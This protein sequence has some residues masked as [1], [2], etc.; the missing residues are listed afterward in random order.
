M[1]VRFN[2][3]YIVISTF[4]YWK[5]WQLASKIVA[6]SFEQNISQASYFENSL[7]RI[8]QLTVL[9]AVQEVLYWF[10]V[11]HF[12]ITMQSSQSNCN[13][14]V[15][16]RSDIASTSSSSSSSIYNN[17][18]LIDSALHRRSC[19]AGRQHRFYKTLTTLKVCVHLTKQ[20]SLLFVL[21]IIKQLSLTDICWIFD[22]L[23]IFSAPCS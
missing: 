4:S 19:A 12:Y 2:W 9:F 1:R 6:I 11:F 8:K 16:L 15:L 20:L 18:I 10:W 14:I 7:L 22:K 5:A 23:S 21:F 13:S 3:S 17:T